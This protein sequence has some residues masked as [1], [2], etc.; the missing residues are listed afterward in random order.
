MLVWWLLLIAVLIGAISSVAVLLIARHVRPTLRREMANAAVIQLPESWIVPVPA[1]DLDAMPLLEAVIK[2]EIEKALI[3]PPPDAEPAAVEKSLIANYK[4]LPPL[5]V[6]K[7]PPAPMPPRRRTGDSIVFCTTCKGRTQHLRQTLPKN[8]ADNPRSKFV[9]LDYG[10]DDDLV[11]YLCSEHLNDI[12]EGRL[13]IYANRSEPKF[14][15][16]HAKNQAYR[17]GI[18]EGADILVMMDADN[19]AG[20]G[21]EDYVRQKFDTTPVSYLVP[22]FAG[23][24]PPGKRYNKERPTHLGRGFYGRLVIRVNDLIKTGGYNEKFDMWGSEDIDLLARLERLGL[25]RGFIDDIYLHAIGHGAWERFREYPEARKYENGSIDVY[26]VTRQAHDTV[27]NYGNFGCGVVYR[28]YNPD[29]IEIRPVPTRLFGIGFQR[30]GTTSLDE[31]FQILGYDSAHWKSGDWAFQIWRE[32][33]RWGSSITVERENALSDNP[34]PLLYDKLDVAYPGSKFILTIRDDDDWLRSVEKFWTYEGNPQRWTWDGDPF[35][36][37]V[38]GII[39][40]RVDFDADVFLTRYR[41]HNQEVMDYFRDR[42]D[43]LLVMRMGNGAGWPEICG[44]LGL[45]M[46]GVPYPHSNRS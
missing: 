16:A 21:F 20:H 1:V 23:L 25:K 24:P 40:G 37:K 14:R 12:R 3:V 18:L 31:A 2:A 29:P 13:I 32:M 35:S 10:S 36:H 8:M 46:P 27:V 26:K 11:T 22:D 38:H 17:C 30:T 5:P 34:I 9:V 7:S 43:D 41:R 6:A 19:L 28:N 45:P 44:F 4:A 33:N 15:I 39:Y 42:P